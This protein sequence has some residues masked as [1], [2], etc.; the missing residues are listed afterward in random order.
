MSPVTWFVALVA[1]I[2][3]VLLLPAG[4]ASEADTPPDA[5]SDPEQATQSDRPDEPSAAPVLPPTGPPPDRNNLAVMETAWMTLEDRRFLVWVASE[6]MEQ[7][8]GLMQVT[9]AELAPFPDGT[10]RGMLFVFPTEQP[11]GFWMYNT[12]IPL[13]I[14]YMAADGTIVK[15]HTMPPNTTQTFPSYRPAQFVLEVNAGVLGAL[16]V[17]EGDKIEI[18]ESVLKTGR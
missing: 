8:F 16:D 4:C 9:S 2:S 12:I 5:A 17:Q 7:T 3:S 14:A 15:I 1:L 18:P 13:D 10:E 6:P 11:R